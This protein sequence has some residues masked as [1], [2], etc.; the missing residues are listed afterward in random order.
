MKFTFYPHKNNPKE[1]QKN[2]QTIKQKRKTAHGSMSSF[3]Q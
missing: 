3:K 1:K 2:K